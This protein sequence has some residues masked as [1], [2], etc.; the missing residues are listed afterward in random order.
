VL[1][2][3]LTASELMRLGLKVTLPLQNSSELIF[4]EAAK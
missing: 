2:E 3:S 1:T 4:I